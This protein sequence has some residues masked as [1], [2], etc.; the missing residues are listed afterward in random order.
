LTLEDSGVIKDQFTTDQGD[1][2][3]VATT[4]STGSDNSKPTQVI[5]NDGTRFIYWIKGA[6]PYNVYGRIEDASGAAL[7]TAFAVTGVGNV[8]DA[9]ISVA[10]STVLGARR[11]VLQVIQSGAVVY[12]TSTDGRTFA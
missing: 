7:A 6:G 5:C 9:G 3:S 12:Y 2:F 1:T 10:E 4:I 11:L 8:D